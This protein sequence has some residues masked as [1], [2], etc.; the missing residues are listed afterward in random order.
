LY[1]VHHL[2]CSGYNFLSDLFPNGKL[3]LEVSP[4]EE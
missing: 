4:C 3:L 1:T 2:V